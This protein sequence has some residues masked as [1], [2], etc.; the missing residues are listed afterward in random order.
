[1]KYFILLSLVILN[2]NA[3]TTEAPANN[4][5]N[6]IKKPIIS[7]TPSK[8]NPFRE[9]KSPLLTGKSKVK[10]THIETKKKV[11]SKK[12]KHK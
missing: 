10:S 1:M 2:I 9:L 7:G 8:D 11:K 5:A 6:K 12:K 4:D 3:Q